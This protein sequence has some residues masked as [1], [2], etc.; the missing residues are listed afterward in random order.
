MLLLDLHT[1]LLEHAAPQKERSLNSQI[2][3]C[4]KALSPPVGIM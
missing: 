2:I 4:N 1:G 3:P